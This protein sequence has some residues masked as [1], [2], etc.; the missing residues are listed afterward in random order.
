[1]EQRG[2]RE[3]GHERDQQK[4]VVAQHQNVT[5]CAL[6]SAP[7]PNGVT[8]MPWNAN[9]R[10]TSAVGMVF[11]AATGSSSAPPLSRPKP[12]VSIS[13]LRT[14]EKPK[15]GAPGLKIACGAAKP[16]VIP[17][18]PP[19]PARKLSVMRTV[20]PSRRGPRM[21]GN[22]PPMPRLLAPGVPM[23]VLVGSTPPRC[24]FGGLDRTPIREVHGVVNGARPAPTLQV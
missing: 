10:P 11:G 24:R 1:L 12:T 15:M 16:G 17:T 21:S 23:R 13:R 9:V 8:T 22:R 18:A 7:V 3:G 14:G 20:S 2:G 4:G 6:L 5:A 19:L